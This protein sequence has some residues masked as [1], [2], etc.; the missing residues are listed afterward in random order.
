MVLFSCKKTERQAT[1]MLIVH[2]DNSI[3]LTRGDTARLVIPLELEGGEDY[4]MQ[5]DDVLTLSLKRSKRDA[6]CAL[7]KVV[8]GT[9]EFHIE[10]KDTKGLDF[11]KYKYD[12]Q[13]TTA[14]G[15]NYTV[16]PYNIFK[17]TAEVG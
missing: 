13:L 5:P 14:S 10:P 17:I 11:Y 4:T 3:E 16:I 6:E 15:D 12:V 8:T 7:Q 2:S 1:K 9:N